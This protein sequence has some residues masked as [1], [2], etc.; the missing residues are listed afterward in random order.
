MRPHKGLRKGNGKSWVRERLLVI[1]R[2][3]LSE[4][5]LHKCLKKRCKFK[6]KEKLA[7]T[8]IYSIEL[9]D[10][11]DE[12][13]LLDQLKKDPSIKSVEL[14]MA[15]PLDVEPEDPGYKESYALPLINAP[16]AWEHTQGEGVIVA[17]LDTGVDASH[18][19]LAGNLIPGWNVL[20]DNADTSDAYG[21]GTKVAGVIASIRG[22]KTGSNGVAYKAKIMPIRIAGSDGYA[23]F[24]TMMSGI[25]W[26]A[27]NGA[28]VVNLSYANA[29]GSPAIWRQAKYLKDTTQGITVISVGN[30]GKKETF[31]AS[32]D[33]LGVSG[34]DSNDNLASWS[35]YGPCVDL[36]APGVNIYTTTKGGGYGKVNGTSF[37]APIVAGSV[38]LI[39]AQDPNLTA[40]EVEHVLLS[41]TKPLATTEAEKEKYGVGRV[42]IGKAIKSIVPE[43]KDTT[44]PTVSIT[45]LTEGMRVGGLVF[46]DVQAE[47]AS[48]IE[49]VKLYVNGM[50]EDTDYQEPYGFAW[51]TSKILDGRYTVLAAASDREGNYA[52]SPALTIYVKN[53]VEPVPE[54]EPNKEEFPYR[55]ELE[56]EL[57]AYVVQAIKDFFNRFFKR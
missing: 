27:N 26:A 40:T 3:G 46:I 55:E 56:R 43:P 25:R 34:T 18:P 10:G 51:D 8:N 30:N 44:P 33:V 17:V 15:V 38:A 50:V 32:A 4:E 47:D 36:C 20:D 52:E 42:D 13:A 12:L 37:A 23:L 35:S 19:D 41:N 49:W 21:H 28:R 24:S 54:P 48:G 53:Y 57:I 5:Y 14:D 9:N 39:M 29:V 1:P 7:D 16:E 6:N 31:L 2:T 11:E 22:N 45:S